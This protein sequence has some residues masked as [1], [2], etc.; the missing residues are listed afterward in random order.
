MKYLKP[1]ELI[2][3]LR[4]TPLVS[5]DL[6][7]QDPEG[8]VLAGLRTNRPAQ[9]YWFVPGGRICKDERLSDA[10]RRITRSELGTEFGMQQARFMGV[11]EH[12]YPD[13]FAGEEGVST[14]YVVLGYHLQL[15]QPLPSLPAEQHED[16]RWFL[17]DELM[18]DEHVH[19]NTKAYF[20]EG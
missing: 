14:H 9:N 19:P 3:A 7:V 10:F 13:N 6:I 2:E 17:V 4:L 16:F 20:K 15:E 1:E 5:I 12:L 18:R 11:Y 8:K